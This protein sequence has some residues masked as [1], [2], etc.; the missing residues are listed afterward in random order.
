MTQKV[1]GE[2]EFQSMPVDRQLHILHS[3]GVYVSKRPLGDK[4]IVLFQLNTF[5][6]E[7]YYQDYRMEVEKILT[8]TQTD[9]LDKYPL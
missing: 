2:A 1:I 3:D 8:C 6:V 4:H 7:V 5:Y 9:I